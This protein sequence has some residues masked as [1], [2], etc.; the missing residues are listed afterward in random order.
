ML[1]GNNTQFVASIIKQL[2]KKFSLKDMGILHLFIGVEVI[3]IQLGLFLSQHKYI[4]DL[5]TNTNMSGAKQVSTPLSTS[6]SLK[7]MDGTTSVDSTEYRRIISSLQYLSL[8][9]PDIS[10]A[11]NSLLN[12]CTSL[13]PF[14]EQPPSNCYVT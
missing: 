6:Q 8:T 10:F 11:V 14:T 4:H 12:S 1:K 13:Q 7:L 3:T 2:G 5:L 9:C